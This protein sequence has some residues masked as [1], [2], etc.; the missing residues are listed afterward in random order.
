MRHSEIT[1]EFE[2]EEF[3]VAIWYLQPDKDPGPDGFSIAF[4]CSF[5]LLLEKYLLNMIRRVFRKKKMG[6]FTSSTYLALIPKE[7]R[8]SSFNRF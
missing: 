3:E 7:S 1:K 2:G 4:Y 8:P 5:S 6:G